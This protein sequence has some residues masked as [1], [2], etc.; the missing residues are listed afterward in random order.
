MLQMQAEL[1]RVRPRPSPLARTAF[2][3][4]F[5]SEFEGL[6]SRQLEREGADFGVV[7]R[8]MLLH[9]ESRHALRQWEQNHF[10]IGG[11][12]LMLVRDVGMLRKAEKG[13]VISV[14]V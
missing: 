12:K 8:C 7:R 4:A 6:H 5:E 3:R 10:S 11:L 13:R 9:R 1:L 14:A 2:H